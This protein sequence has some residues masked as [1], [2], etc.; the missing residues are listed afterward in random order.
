MEQLEENLKLLEEICKEL[1][2]TKIEYD[3]LMRFAK[4]VIIL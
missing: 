2:A 4:Q 3:S 1:E